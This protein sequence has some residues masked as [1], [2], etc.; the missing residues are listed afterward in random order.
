M[1]E[2]SGEREEGGGRKEERELKTRI[3]FLIFDELT[4]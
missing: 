4:V 3:L 1:R 2:D